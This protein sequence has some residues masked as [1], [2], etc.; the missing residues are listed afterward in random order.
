MTV[1]NDIIILKLNKE[2]EIDTEKKV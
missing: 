2:V 1:I